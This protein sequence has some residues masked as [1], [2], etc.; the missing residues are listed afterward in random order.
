VSDNRNRYGQN[1]NN[2]R[3][4]YGYVRRKPVTITYLDE[5]LATERTI[6]LNSTFRHRDFFEVAGYN[7]NNIF[8]FEYEEGSVYFNNEDSKEVTFNRIF[9]YAPYV[10]Y[11][12]EPTPDNSHNINVFGTALP[13]QNRMY[14]G[15]SA[16]FTGYVHYIA[17][18]APSW[19]QPS[20]SGS[21]THIYAGEYDL[22]NVSEYTAS[23]SLPTTGSNYVYYDTIHE[24]FNSFTA[25]T[26]TLNVSASNTQS[27]NT[28]SANVTNKLHFI[29]FRIA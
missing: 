14:I 4:T 15:T 27:T 7:P 26:F 19:S 22:F 23:Y 11:F 8:S 20:T 17:V 28:L 24:N 29:I 13:T 16:P 5:N 25:N 18:A 10:I 21:S 3:R 9:T 2:W 6:D 1:A 12:A